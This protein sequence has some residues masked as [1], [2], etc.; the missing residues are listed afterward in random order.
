MA[1]NQTKNKNISEEVLKNEY[2]LYPADSWKEVNVSGGVCVKNEANNDRYYGDDAKFLLAM[3]R[4][5]EMRRQKVKV[6][7]KEQ[8]FSYFEL[9]NSSCGQG[10]NCFVDLLSARG[11]SIEDFYNKFKNKTKSFSDSKVFD[12]LVKE[13]FPYKVPKSLTNRLLY[14]LTTNRNAGHNFYNFYSVADL[15]ER[16]VEDKYKLLSDKPY[17]EQGLYMNDN[18]LAVWIAVIGMGHSFHKVIGKYFFTKGESHTFLTNPHNLNFEESIVFSIAY[19]YSKNNAVALKL[20]KIESLSNAVLSTV[21]NI[22]P[23]TSIFDI[24]KRVSAERVKHFYDLNPFNCNANYNVYC[25]LRFIFDVIRLLSKEGVGVPIS[26]LGEVVD[27]FINGYWVSYLEAFARGDLNASR[28]NELNSK[29]FVLSLAEKEKLYGLDLPYESLGGNYPYSLRLP[30][31]ELLNRGL[32]FAG[33]QKE[34]VAWH[35]ELSR[36]KIIGNGSWEGMGI[37]DCQW[38][39]KDKDG[40]VE[41]VVYIEQIKTASGLQEEG[42][43]MRHCVSSYASSC[44]SGYSAI[45]S[46]YRISTYGSKKRLVT[47]RLNNNG[48]IVEAKGLANRPI[49]QGEMNYLKHFANYNGLRVSSY[50]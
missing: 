12:S 14:D 27:Y 2:F 24:R 6:T 10:F 47:I 41:A 1:K 36:K 8:L 15:K 16:N 37:A 3:I 19:N 34:T 48:V 5:E 43:Q 11:M 40:N 28:H 32:N 38:E 9:K 25:K 35:H 50:L 13:C 44:R 45:F 18:S 17:A 42:S 30:L 20:A 46:M 49:K 31:P 7:P 4:L 21:F 33:L 26:Q 23:F 39:E 29:K 22:K